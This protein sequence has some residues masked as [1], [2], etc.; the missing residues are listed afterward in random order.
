M[1]I[2]RTM[3]GF[4]GFDIECDKCGQSQYLDFDWG[5]FRGAIAE[6]KTSGW[7]IFK[8][9]HEDWIHICRDCQENPKE[10]ESK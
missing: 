3:G 7:K 5:N 4:R 6:A 8:D 9:E 10:E 2:E 1:S